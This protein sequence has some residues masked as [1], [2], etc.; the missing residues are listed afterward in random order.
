ME[1]FLNYVIFIQEVNSCDL[2]RNLRVNKKN[3][4]QV[5][6]LLPNKI[7]RKPPTHYETEHREMTE[8]YLLKEEIVFIGAN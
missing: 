2:T 4:T 7:R 3:L 6:S 5:F 1:L 8:R